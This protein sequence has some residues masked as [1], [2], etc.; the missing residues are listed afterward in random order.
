MKW[1]VSVPNVG[2]P[3]DLVRFAREVD[4]AQWDGFF[5]EDHLQLDPSLRLDV[6]DP[7]GLLGAIA[8]VTRRVRLGTM[9]TLVPRRPSTLAKEVLTLDR[10]ST[11]RAILGVGR[12]LP[13]DDELGAFSEPTGSSEH[14]VLLD[15]GLEVI[16]LMLRGQ[17]VR[18]A[19]GAFEIDAE[20]L[21]ASIQR[22]RPPIWVAAEAPHRGPIERAARFDGVYAVGSGRMPLSPD[23]LV[24]YLG[25]LAGRPG[26]DVVAGLA[27]GHRPEDYEAIGVTWLVESTWPEGDWLTELRDRVAGR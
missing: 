4:H 11:G 6:H 5:V 19:H 9:G 27:P 15:D 10:L 21:P 24:A 22:P 3:A 8:E 20:R 18:H 7:W 13:A 2:K 17:P 16:D 25:P 1:A 26:F 14:T 12:G 23:A